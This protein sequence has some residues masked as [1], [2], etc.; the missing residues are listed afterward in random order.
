LEKAPL[1]ER[2]RIEREQQDEIRP[3][4][5]RRQIA[6]ME[7]EPAIAAYRFGRRSAQN[8]RT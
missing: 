2:E 8:L 4:L 1:R 3:A 5:V 7:E 6:K